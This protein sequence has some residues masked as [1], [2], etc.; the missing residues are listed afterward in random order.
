MSAPTKGTTTASTA[1]PNERSS[2]QE[3]LLWAAR[4]YLPRIA[5]SCSF[6]G[7]G[8]M[9]LTH[10][11]SRVAPEVPLLFIDTGFLFPET[12]ALRQLLEEE[13]GLT[14]L[15]FRPQLS[16]QEQ[17]AKYGRDLWQKDPDL[18]CHLR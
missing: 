10:M 14:V 11:L 17:E 13:L 5:M 12:Y 9:V 6:G 3:V 16:P 8:G 2:P 1:V 4:R 15:V 18:C 7:V